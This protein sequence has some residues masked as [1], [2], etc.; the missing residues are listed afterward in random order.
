VE[1]VSELYDLPS[2]KVGAILEMP[3][4]TVESIEKIERRISSVV[5]NIL[6]I[7][8]IR[9][10]PSLL[11]MKS[12]G[13]DAYESELRR[14]YGLTIKRGLNPLSEEISSLRSLEQY[15]QRIEEDSLI[16]GS[17]PVRPKYEVEIERVLGFPF[18]DI[19]EVL[20]GFKGLVGAAYLPRR[21]ILHNSGLK[22]HKYGERVI[23]MLRKKGVILEHNKSGTDDPMSLNPHTRE[24]EL[25]ELREYMDDYL[26]NISMV[27]TG[28]HF[29]TSP[30]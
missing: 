15:K 23:D 9:S 25:P 6:A 20:D 11:G 2:E 8:I 16:D 22:D 3:G 21:H 1:L 29:S 24:I 7:E 18:Q 30:K 5:G 17:T 4:V 27:R 26:R 19:K 12:T 10:N 13:F 28:N 14:V